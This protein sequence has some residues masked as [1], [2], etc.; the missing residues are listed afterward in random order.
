MVI[1]LSGVFAQDTLTIYFDKNWKEITDKNMASYYRKAF[2]DS[3][4]HWAVQDYFLSDNI[5]MIGTFTSKNFKI[6]QGHFT[7]FYENGR[8]E[9]E[10]DCINNKNEGIWTAWHENGQKRSEGL[11]R[12]NFIQDKWTYWHENGQLK[13]EGVFINGRSEGKWK[14]WYNT[15]EKKSEG[16]YLHDRKD[17]TWNYYYKTGQIESAEEYM[18][19]RLTL[20]NG[21]FDNGKIKYK[22]DCSKGI[23]NG[24]WTYWNVDGKL[25]LK[26]NFENEMK[27][28]EW[29]RYF[30]NGDQLKMYY[31]KGNLVS[32]HLGGIVKND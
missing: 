22:G 10:G 6:K 28:G 12:N 17:S 11:F 20:I 19:G 16:K 14:Y 18:N 8:K 15:G 32:K 13:S 2:L 23:N 30:P 7:Y 21:Y 1:L 27:V 25:V 26:G 9:S 31:V 29:I 4:K 3:H 24:E 5:Q